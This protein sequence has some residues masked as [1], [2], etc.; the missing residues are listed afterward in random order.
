MQKRFDVKFTEEAEAFI[1]SLDQKIQRKVTFNIQKSR[2]VDDPGVLKK[3]TK[4]IWEFR[5]RYQNL[6]IRLLAFWDKKSKSLIICTHGFIKKTQKT[7]KSEI[8]KAS[9]I[10]KEYLN[11][12]S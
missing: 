9:R 10:R 1:L 11:K 3:I 2:E 8:V 12:K 6:Q 7:P 5:T 4:E